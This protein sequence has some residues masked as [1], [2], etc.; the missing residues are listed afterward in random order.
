MVR[1]KFVPPTIQTSVNF[2]KPSLVFNNS[3]SDYAILLI[4]RRS[5]QWKNR[6]KVRLTSTR[7]KADK[8][9]LRESDLNKRL[10]F[11]TDS[12]THNDNH[13]NLTK[14]T[15]FFHRQRIMRFKTLVALILNHLWRFILYKYPKVHLS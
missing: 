9:T 1:D 5:F 8:D 13:N 11:W 2:A 7:N 4:L 3:L 12:K 14:D 10:R 6:E 15:N